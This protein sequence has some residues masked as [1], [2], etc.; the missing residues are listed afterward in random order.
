M[1]RIAITPGYTISRVLKGG[2]QLAGG[3]G[4]I[5]RATAL[6]DMARFV[7]AGITTFD[8]ADIYTGVEELIGQFLRGRRTGT[9]VQ[10]HTKFVPD[11]D[12]LA[13][14]TRR[15]VEAAID[16]SLAPPRR[17]TARPGPVSLVE[18][19][20]APVCRG[21][22]LAGRVPAR[23]QDR[24]PWRHQL[25][26]RPAA[27]TDRRRRSRRDAP[28][29]ILGPGPATCPRPSDGASALD[30]RVL[31]AGRHPAPLLRRRRRRLPFGLATSTSLRRSN[32]SRIDRW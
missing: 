15:D 20:R 4:A 22:R 27:R 8:C 29:S 13:T 30:G 5:D 14:L 3:H 21:G 1:P 18:L 6:D 24:E 12:T 32:R 26:H 7:D 25:R 2:W 9:P 10:V 17:R 23:R 28:G 16:R 11:L 19:R 31:R